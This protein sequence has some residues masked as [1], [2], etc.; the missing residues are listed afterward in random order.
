MSHAIFPTDEVLIDIAVA[1]AAMPR[2]RTRLTGR[3]GGQEVST[4]LKENLHRLTE[5]ATRAQIPEIVAFTQKHGGYFK[6]W[7]GG[8]LQRW[9]KNSLSEPGTG[10]SV[11]SIEERLTLAFLQVR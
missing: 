3:H 8:A 7:R 6:R 1:I 10:M 2:Q 5:E 4:Y 11:L 9:T